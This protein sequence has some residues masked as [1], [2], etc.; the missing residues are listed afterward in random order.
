MSF[1]DEIKT[2]LGQVQRGRRVA[3]HDPKAPRFSQEAEDE[4]QLKAINKA[5]AMAEVLEPPPAEEEKNVMKKR[6]GY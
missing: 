4:R 1:Q 5:N 6:M 3:T 2:Y